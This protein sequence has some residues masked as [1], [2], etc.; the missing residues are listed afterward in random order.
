[1]KKLTKGE[2]IA[3]HLRGEAVLLDYHLYNAEEMR[4]ISEAVLEA[5]R[6]GERKGAQQ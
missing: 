6:G 4:E 5:M 1:M 2:A 3:Q